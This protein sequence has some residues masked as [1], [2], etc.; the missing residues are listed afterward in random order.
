MFLL[1][2]RIEY[3]PLSQKSQKADYY[4]EIKH[5]K[6]KYCTTPEYNN[7]TN[8]VLDVKITAKRL[9][10]ESGLNEKIKTLA[11]KE[12]TKKGKKQ[13]KTKQT[14][15]KNKTAKVESK[16]EQDQTVKLQTSDWSIFVGQSY[17]E[18][19]GAQLNLI[20]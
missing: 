17:F 1:L 8:N 20:L 9:V 10:H 19:D 6:D 12:E 4:A 11:T 18:N 7:F 13:S 3:L 5:I 15:E 14:K 16:P 2:L